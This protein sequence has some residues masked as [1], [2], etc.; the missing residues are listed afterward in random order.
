LL[1]IIT[2]LGGLNNQLDSI[3]D[4]LLSGGEENQIDRHYFNLLPHKVAREVMASWLRT[5]NLRGF[6]RLA[7][8]RLTIAS[9][10]AKPGQYFPIM[11]GHNLEVRKDNLIL[12]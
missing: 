10:V 11:N 6:D 7:I 2:K 12:V 9:K 4:Q 1:S 3:I 5:N 8:E